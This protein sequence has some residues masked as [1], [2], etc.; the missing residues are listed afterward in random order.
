MANIQLLAINRT[1][2]DST[3][4][5]PDSDA[6]TGLKISTWEAPAGTEAYALQVGLPTVTGG[7]SN[8]YSIYSEGPM[9]FKDSLVNESGK[10]I[11]STVGTTNNTSYTLSLPR[12]TS[13]LAT[14]DDVVAARNG[15][16]VHDSVR[17]A[18]T[19][20]VPKVTAYDGEVLNAGVPLTSSTYNTTYAGSMFKGAGHNGATQPESSFRVA[21]GLTIAV[22]SITA[23]GGISTYTIPTSGSNYK[24]AAATKSQLDIGGTS[25][26]IATE[27]DYNVTAT[28]GSQWIVRLSAGS[29]ATYAS[30]VVYIL[31]RGLGDFTTQGDAFDEA[32][33]LSSANFLVT[34]LGSA[35]S[36]SDGTNNLTFKMLAM[37]TVVR[38]ESPSA[39]GTPAYFWVKKNIDNVAYAVDSL[40][41]IHA[42][43][44]FTT[45]TYSTVVTNGLVSGYKTGAS[46]T[47]SSILGTMV[48][49]DPSIVRRVWFVKDGYSTSSTATLGTPYYPRTNTGLGMY[50]NYTAPAGVVTGMTLT[51]PGSGYTTNVQ[52]DSEA[53]Y[54][55]QIGIPTGKMNFTLDLPTG[56]CG[57]TATIPISGGI[58]GIATTFTGIAGTAPTVSGNDYRTFSNVQC[59][60]RGIATV[61]AKGK[62]TIYTTATS[63]GY[64][65]TNTKIFVIAEP[66]GLYEAGTPT[67]IKILGNALGGVSGTNDLTFTYVRTGNQPIT[68]GTSGAYVPPVSAEI[69]VSPDQDAPVVWYMKNPSENTVYQILAELSAPSGIDIGARYFTQ[70]SQVWTDV[71]DADPFVLYSKSTVIGSGLKLIATSSAVTIAA[72]GK[73]DWYRAG[74]RIYLEPS[75]TGTYV[76]VATV[77]DFRGIGK[78][79]VLTID[80]FGTIPAANLLKGGLYNA[81]FLTSGPDTNSSSYGTTGLPT[82]ASSSFPVP[83]EYLTNVSTLSMMS[84]YRSYVY[85]API[86]SQNSRFMNSDGGHCSRISATSTTSLTDIRALNSYHVWKWGQYS[87]YTSSFYNSTTGFATQMTTLTYGF[88]KPVGPAK[89]DDITILEGTRVLVKNQDEKKF[90]GIYT[91]SYAK[92]SPYVFML[93]RSTDFDSTTAVLTAPNGEVNPNAFVFV[94]EGTVNKDSGWTCTTD[95]P[96]TLGSSEIIWAKFTGASGIA[97]DQGVVGWTGTHTFSKWGTLVDDP[98]PLGKFTYFGDGTNWILPTRS[99]LQTI[100]SLE[101]HSDF[102]LK[103]SANNATATTRMNLGSN[104]VDNIF[105]SATNGFEMKFI[106]TKNG[107]ADTYAAVSDGDTLGKLSFKGYTGTAVANTLEAASIVATAKGT[108]STTLLGGSLS[109]LTTPSIASTASQERLRID[110]LGAVTIYGVS[111]STNNVA[112][113]ANLLTNVTTGSVNLFTSVT[114]N[115]DGINIG[116]AGSQVTIGTTGG[117]SSLNIKGSATSGTAT[118]TT[119]AATGYLF[120]TS[121]TSISLG[122]SATAITMGASS[123]NGLPS[124]VTVG[125]VLG[126][127]GVVTINNPTVTMANTTGTSSGVPTTFNMNGSTNLIIETST[128]DS[129]ASIFNGTLIAAGRLFGRT[130]AISIGSAKIPGTTINPQTVGIGGTTVNAV[131]LVAPTVSVTLGG[132][133]S[134]WYAYT[135]VYNDGSESIAS[136]VSSLASS[137]ATPNNSVT[138]IHIANAVSYNLYRLNSATAT[139][140]QKIAVTAALPPASTT[141]FADTSIAPI[142]SNLFVTVPAQHSS[143]IGQSSY[144]L[145]FSANASTTRGR[146]SLA[147]GGFAANATP[148]VPIAGSSQMSTYVLSAYT[149]ALS[150]TVTMTTDWIGTAG[151]APTLLNQ[152]IIK[153]NS[154]YAFSILVSISAS[155]DATQGSMGTAG[156]TIITEGVIS[157]TTGAVSIQGNSVISRCQSNLFG[158]LGCNTTN[159]PSITLVDGDI[160]GIFAIQAKS[161]TGS[162]LSSPSARS[163]RWTAVV[164]MSECG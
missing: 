21:T 31:P 81:V 141:V 36:G 147:S 146:F 24:S 103:L 124:G 6:S 19:A 136:P 109:F 140:G 29:S 51:K 106:R 83:T 131:P 13:T 75:G 65:A 126:T 144:Q 20:A 10:I 46:L 88:I 129:I 69:S 134:Y 74:D 108:V 3:V 85:S 91:T 159:A 151:T 18:T 96:I 121:A 70:T 50:V 160:N 118:L 125:G 93:Y 1:T 133:T 58:P 156:A 158:T 52:S 12:Q 97:E 155:G 44:G 80:T 33:G 149:N 40:H 113:I 49:N 139:T 154:A 34:I 72:G 8:A 56:R 127:G 9:S 42:G 43:S 15:L 67:A 28:N 38:V 101:L 48:A 4:I 86:S 17:V 123:G 37:P 102:V 27:T 14:I 47:L 122:G 135:A 76:T 16:D 112:G 132:S 60:A 84:G 115:T 100:Y 143:V 45:G 145:G 94:E 152:I 11:L 130:T 78:G 104:G 162:T 150:Q 105:G 114:T 41:L 82:G 64:T 2:Q 35:F 23:S 59:Y 7:A 120:N 79:P 62:F 87:S 111:S 163:L 89:I 25:P 117:N 164:T 137:N 90:N 95:A 138:I 161:N 53:P 61:D 39:T 153:Q 5:N 22:A 73:G 32:G 99:T 110:E 68:I 157:R 107:A 26:T 98:N 54:P 30:R 92:R 57:V 71:S 128:I 66:E 119:N 55:I 63:G 148:T 116:G 77:D 142:A